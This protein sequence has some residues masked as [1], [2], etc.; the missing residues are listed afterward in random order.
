[1]AQSQHEG[2]EGVPGALAEALRLFPAIGQ[3]D[4]AHLHVTGVG[5]GI[6]I[7]SHQVLIPAD[8]HDGDPASLH[9]RIPSQ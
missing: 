2:G 5:D 1:M 7:L 4:L 3:E 8:A 6:F 9:I